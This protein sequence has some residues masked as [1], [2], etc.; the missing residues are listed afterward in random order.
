[1]ELLLL[2]SDLCAA[3]TRPVDVRRLR[4]SHEDKP[5]VITRDIKRTP[6]SSSFTAFA[7]TPPSD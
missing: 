4:M 2:G 6:N 3:D 5:E 7:A 1:M